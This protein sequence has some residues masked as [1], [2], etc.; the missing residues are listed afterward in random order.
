ML[1]REHDI[2]NSQ[3]LSSELILRG[4]EAISQVKGKVS[5]EQEI[6]EGM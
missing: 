6:I 3:V 4:V 2:G 5:M 1:I